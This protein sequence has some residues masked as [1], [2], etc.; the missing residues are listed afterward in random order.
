[1]IDIRETFILVEIGIFKI[2]QRKDYKT[3]QWG[4]PE[5]NHK[6]SRDYGIEQLEN[7]E[8]DLIKAK[9]VAWFL[10]SHFKKQNTPEAYSLELV[11]E[12]LKMITGDYD[13]QK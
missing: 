8:R 10:N 11:K 13:H 12:Q 7:N 9:N 1:M 2:K 3:G 6:T 5:I 4:M